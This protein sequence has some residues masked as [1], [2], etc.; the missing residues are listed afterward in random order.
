LHDD[1]D[2]QNRRRWRHHFGHRSGQVQEWRLPF[3]WS[4][5]I[6]S[7]PPPQAIMATAHKLARIVYNLMRYGVA[8]MKQTAL[9]RGVINQRIRR[10]RRMF[11]WGVEHELVSATVLHALQAI[12]GLKLGRTEARET[13]LVKPV[14]RAVV[15]DTL[16]LLR[17][18]QADMS[19]VAT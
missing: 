12:P 10:I 4:T 16:P 18:M 3:A 8:Y 6:A 7:I 19:A 5:V 14:S 1:D 11:R 17:P 13:E 9:A 2:R 15:E